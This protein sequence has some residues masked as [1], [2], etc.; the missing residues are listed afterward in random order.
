MGPVSRDHPHRTVWR[1]RTAK[2]QSVACAEFC[3]RR[4]VRDGYVSG[5]VACAND[6]ALVCDDKADD[7]C[8]SKA[9]AALSPHDGEAD[10]I[11]AC[12]QKRTDCKGFSDDN[13]LGVRVL[14][15]S[16]F[17]AAKDC[18]AKPCADIGGCLSA[19]YK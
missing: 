19:L 4:C 16:C 11:T 15:D 5:L 8:A 9:A 17:G 18:V 6:P 3:T 7:N 2:C 14:D 1:C 12:L 10:F 13:C